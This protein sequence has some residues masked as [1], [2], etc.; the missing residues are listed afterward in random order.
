MDVGSVTWELVR[1]VESQAL[2]S[3]CFFQILSLTGASVVG[4]NFQ[5][6]GPQEAKPSLAQGTCMPSLCRLLATPSHFSSESVSPAD[7]TD[8]IASPQLTPGLL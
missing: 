3:P 6:R 8:T 2:S 5:K 7:G 4:M 1:N